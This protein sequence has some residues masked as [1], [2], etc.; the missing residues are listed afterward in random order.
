ML[1]I[2]KRTFLVKKYL[3]TK[4]YKKTQEIFFLNLEKHRLAKLQL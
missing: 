3:E 4:S 1:S 2:E